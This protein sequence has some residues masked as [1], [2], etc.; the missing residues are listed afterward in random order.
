[1]GRGIP[2]SVARPSVRI[3]EP[4]GMNPG[5]KLWSLARSFLASAA[6][7][8]DFGG[9]FSVVFPGTGVVLI[10][11]HGPA[12]DPA[13]DIG[14]E[15]ARH[16]ETDLARTRLRGIG[17]CAEAPLPERLR[18]FEFTLLEPSDL[19]A[20][21]GRVEAVRAQFVAQHC[22]AVARALAMNQRFGEARIGQQPGLL[23]RIEH[24]IELGFGLGMRPELAAQLE[25]AMLAPRQQ[26]QRPALQGQAGARQAG[27]RPA[28][29]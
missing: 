2:G 27:A 7:H 8:G 19:A 11:R 5:G 4:S 15:A 29:R 26:A 12:D 20:D 1:M 6:H 14:T 24:G 16:Q 9:L 23:E 18:A 22:R 10:G 17:R 25:P 28:R 3:T 13:H 21:D